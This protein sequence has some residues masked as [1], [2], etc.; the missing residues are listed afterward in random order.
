[1]GRRSSIRCS[2]RAER[3]MTQTLDID[4]P[5][6]WPV[7]V[8][9][10]VDEVVAAHD[11]FPEAEY[12]DEVELSSYDREL[13]DEATQG[14][15]IMGYHA[16]RLLEHEIR[17]VREEG[18]RTLS[19]EATALRLD[20]AVE[21]GA[22]D[23]ALAD[24]LRPGA[25]ST[26][27]E[28]NR[29]KQVCLTSSRNALRSRHGF[30]RFFTYWGGEAI[31]WHRPDGDPVLTTLS[32]IG[33]SAVVSAA[34]PIGQVRQRLANVDVARALVVKRLG[35]SGGGSIYLPAV[36]SAQIV[37]VILDG[38]ERWDALAPLSER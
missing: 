36:P 37:N 22:L 14:Q 27:N 5:S 19:A 1:M 11:A 13:I 33:R 18:L 32:G 2:R 4:V 38:T 30:R 23:P 26:S 28:S 17:S 7:E 15:A 16:T 35:L 9:E 20:A 31:Y 12:S 29:A 21:V 25:I 10:A 3:L 34:I 24:M 6:S 8:V